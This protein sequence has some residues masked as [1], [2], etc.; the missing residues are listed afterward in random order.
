MQ[1]LGRGLGYIESFIVVVL[2]F[3]QLIL[4]EE[5]VANPLPVI[6]AFVLVLV[7]AYI[8]ER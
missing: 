3:M 6:I 5:G 1:I 4:L 7:W 8:F 2:V